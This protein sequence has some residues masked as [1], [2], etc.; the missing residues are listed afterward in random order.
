MSITLTAAQDLNGS[1]SVQ[2]P[3]T[4]STC[5]TKQLTKAAALMFNSSLHACLYLP[6]MILADIDLKW[7][8]SATC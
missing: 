5:S 2:K 1:W 4:G 3:I 7:L 8:L 6:S